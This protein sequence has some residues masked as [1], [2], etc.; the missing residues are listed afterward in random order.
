MTIP[1]LNDLYTSIKQD[2]KNKLGITS[3]VGKTVLNAISLVQAAKLKIYYLSLSFVYKNIF[4][5]Q[6]VSVQKGGSLE[7]FGK[8]KLNRLPYPATAGEYK[9]AITGSVG[10]TIRAGTTFKSLDSSTNPDKLFITNINTTLIASPETI[11]IR[12]LELGSTAQLESG[13][14]LQVTAPIENI[15]SFANITAVTTIAADAESFEEYREK[16]I[17][18]YQT[19]PQGGSKTDYRLWSADVSTV[20]YVYPYVRDSYAGEINLYIEAYEDDS[21]DGHGTPTAATLSDV[22]TVCN[23]DPDTSKPLNERGRMPMGVFN[24]NYLVISPLPV[25]VTITGLSDVSYLTEIEA[26]IKEFLKDIRPF[27]GGADNPN[28][29]NKDKLYLTDIQGIVRDIIGFNATFSAVEMTVDSVNY[30]IYQFENGDIPYI[31]SVTA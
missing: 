11:E 30:T 28:D 18:S 16:V 17:E 27:V 3:F 20:R 15:D 19:E 10:A 31:N 9:L 26:Q 2:L 1:S 13:D 12:A 8:V 25:D 21:T 4:V 22:E 7:R 14:E 24:V 5:D 23:F 29:I 6:A